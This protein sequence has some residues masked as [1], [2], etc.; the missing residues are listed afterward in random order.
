MKKWITATL[1]LATAAVAQQTH[2]QYEP[3]NAPGDGQRLLVQFTGDWD[4]VKTFFP[5][6]GKPIVTKGSGK[7]VHDPGRQV[8]AVGLHLLQFVDS[9]SIFLRWLKA[10]SL[11]GD[12]EKFTQP[13]MITSTCGLGLLE[14]SAVAESVGVAHSISKLIRSLAGSP[15]L[16]EQVA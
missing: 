1:L 15:E 16:D 3:P 8:S 14:T 2:N 12:P 10:A 13:A 5:M 11:A 6:N 7:Q 9:A 4:V